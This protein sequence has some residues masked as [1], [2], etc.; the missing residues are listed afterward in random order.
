MLDQ[1]PFGTWS[2]GIQ[3]YYKNIFNPEKPEDSS[4]DECVNDML[5]SLNGN[6]FLQRH[7]F[8]KRDENGVKQ[9]KVKNVDMNA[10]MKEYIAEWDKMNASFKKSEKR[11]KV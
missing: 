11:K 9:K 3:G 10:L 1:N 4:L 7:L 6:T 2:A 8:T 5:F